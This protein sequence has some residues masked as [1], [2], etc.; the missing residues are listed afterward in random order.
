MPAVSQLL[1]LPFFFTIPRGPGAQQLLGEG[2]PLDGVVQGPDQAE[3]LGR[4][5][6][7]QGGRQGA[8][9]AVERLDEVVCVFDYA[10]DDE[11]LGPLLGSGLARAVARRA[12]PAALR[13]AVLERCAEYRTGSGGY[14]LR[15]VFRLLV[16]RPR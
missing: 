1:D 12:G 2:Q 7:P 3:L 5:G 15:N 9:L 6:G 16:A 8:G 13:T 10:D 4:Q 11:L 14:R